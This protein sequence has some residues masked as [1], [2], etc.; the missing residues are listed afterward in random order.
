MRQLFEKL[1]KNDRT[2]FYAL[3]E[4][5]LLTRK[6]TFLITGNP[7]VFMQICKDPSLKAA[8]MDANTIITP[9]GEGVVHAARKLDYPI[10]GKIAGVDTVEQLFSMC[11]RHGRSL[12]VL[13][14][15]QEVLDALKEKISLKYSN[16][17]VL[18][19]VNGYGFDETAVFTS[20]RALQ[21]DVVLAALGVPRQEKIIADHLQDLDR[22]IFVGCGG[23]LD[24][25][26]GC[27]KR[28]PAIFIRCKLEWAYRLMKEPKRLRRFYNSNIKFLLDIRKLKQSRS[29]TAQ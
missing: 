25:L 11:H 29:G 9:D 5:R 18:G 20:I 23:S 24:V 28:A 19:M 6:K 10:W 3:L 1:Y 22:G 17:K 13:G 21:P 8:A 15:R 27:K 2:S 12:F 7:E 4:E 14:S 16:M 26:S